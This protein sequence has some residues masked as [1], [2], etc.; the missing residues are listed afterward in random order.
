MTEGAIFLTLLFVH[1]S[2]AFVSE[3]IQQF[4]WILFIPVAVALFV[5]H[6]RLNHT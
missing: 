2:F 3:H 5:Q 1:L 4:N 6:R